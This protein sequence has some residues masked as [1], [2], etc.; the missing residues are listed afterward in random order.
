MT[1]HTGPPLR[2][3]VVALLLSSGCSVAAPVL[4]PPEPLTAS[5][6]RA[7]AALIALEDALVYDANLFGAA[8]ESSSP[9]VR[10]RAALAA[11]RI[12]SDEAR[13]LVRRLLLDPD[14]AVAASAAFATGLLADSAATARLATLMHPDTARRRPTVAIEAAIALGHIGTAEAAAVLVSFL[15][16]VDPQTTDLQ[17]VAA[18]A[19]VAAWRAGEP[20]IEPFARW[21]ESPDGETRWRAAFALARSPG[22]GAVEALLRLLPDPSPEVRANAL[23]GLSA[24]AVQR[25][26]VSPD[27]V[28]PLLVEALGTDSYPVRIEAAR[29][30]GTYRSPP[31]LSAIRGLLTDSS[32]H[33]AVVAAEALGAMGEAGDSAIP[34]LSR[35]A[36]D[37]A[38]P[39]YL[40]A[41]ALRSL[42]AMDPSARVALLADLADDPSWRIRAA[43]VEGLARRRVEA[44]PDL[45]TL[46]RDSDAR[47]AAGAL[48]AIVYSLGPDEIGQ[49]RP[50][51]LEQ[52]RSPHVAVRIPSLQGLAWL[53]D[54]ATYPTLLDAYDAARRDEEPEA[55]VAAIDAIADLGLAGMMTPERAFF[56]RF[57]RPEAREVHRRALVRFGQAAESAW[58]PLPEEASP[59]M[60]LSYA[61]LVLDW[62]SP[63]AEETILPRVRLTTE[64]GVVDLLLLA[65][66]APRTVANYLALAEARFYDGLEWARLVPDFMI[67]GGDPVGDT[68]GDPGYSIPDEQNRHRF[69]TGSAGMALAG[70]NTAGSQFF[71]THSPQPHLDGEFTVFGQVISGQDVVERL[72]PGDRI[73]SVREITE[74]DEE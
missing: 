49:A 11:G 52:V 61:E 69:G 19:L 1:D 34:D 24:A 28:V 39:P 48:Q 5:E 36:Q 33:L 44:I 57:P 59:E 54:P 47:V 41:T 53:S 13:P 35:L 74:S 60:R 14:S 50:L 64:H 38:A 37:P 22:V 18:A 29:A 2:I 20:S 10:V 71:L 62:I 40:R 27:V 43:V 30:L 46:A 56:A 32:S 9:E 55:A 42:L 7:V 67:Q 73:V 25:S 72:L 23:R 17:R 21:A 3:L 58:G 26:L 12:G 68:T 16:S 31:A 4:A 45:Q 63:T 66:D 6:G 70:P 51:L 15:S 8:A 65:R